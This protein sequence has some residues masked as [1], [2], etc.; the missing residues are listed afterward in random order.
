MQIQFQ[1]IPDE[2]T[3]HFHMAIEQVEYQALHYHSEVEVILVLSGSP[4][5]TINGE[6]QNYKKKDVLVIS[7]HD[8]H[9]IYS[10]IKPSIL[11]KLYINPIFFNGYFP[12]MKN[13]RFTVNKLKSRNHELF[14]MTIIG[15]AKM[16]IEKDKY[17]QINSASFINILLFDILN[18][19]AYY[20]ESDERPFE[21]SSENKRMS[22][23]IEY[24]QKNY[25]KKIKLDDLPQDLT[26]SPTYLSHFIK[27][28]LN[29]TFSDFLTYVR[30]A[31]AKLMIHE[32]NYTLG[33]ISV[34]VGFSDY[35]YMNQAFKNN[36]GMTPKEYREK[37]ILKPT[38]SYDNEKRDLKTDQEMLEVLASFQEKH[39]LR[40]FNDQ[41][42]QVGI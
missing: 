25:Y 20:E 11:L 26:L 31:N 35:R 30:Y 9:A 39:N 14:L 21:I 34:I 37:I 6:Q 29:R 16:F 32:M 4:T 7:P 13:I 5:V 10:E 3:D 28:N 42:D 24:V 18:G 1:N 41:D 2:S 23:I 22:S 38:F 8:T 40:E 15:L 19:C 33:D 17:Y 27:K 36:L 12:K